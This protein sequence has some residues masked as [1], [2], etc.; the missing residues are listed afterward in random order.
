MGKYS[1]VWDFDFVRGWFEVRTEYEVGI[2]QFKAI[3]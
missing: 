3:L 1:K 2:L